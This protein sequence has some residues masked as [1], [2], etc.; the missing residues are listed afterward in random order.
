ME[1]LPFEV[2]K[3]MVDDRSAVKKIGKR[4]WDESKEMWEIAAPAILT[5]VAQF[6]IG[7]VTVAFVGHLGEIE[8]S[9]VSVVQNVIEGF[10]CGIMVFLSTIAV[11]V[12]LYFAL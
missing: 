7:F 10:V 5:A 6:S 1:M 2:D 8:L 11:K 3:Q 12:N 9:A 4:S